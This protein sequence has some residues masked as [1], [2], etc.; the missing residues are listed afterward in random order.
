MTR[1]HPLPALRARAL[2]M[3]LSAGLVGSLA[4]LSLGLSAQPLPSTQAHQGN[5]ASQANQPTPP[6]LLIQ[7]APAR[8]PMS[9]FVVSVPVGEGGKLG[10]LERADRHCQALA[11]SAGAAPGLLWRAYLSTQGR[12]APGASP[13]GVDARDRIGTGPW[14]NAAGTLVATDLGELHRQGAPRL[15][16]RTALDE[17]GQPVPGAVHDILTGSR[18]DGTAASPLDADATCGNWTL[19]EDVDGEGRANGALVGHHDRGSALKGA[20][21]ESWNSAHRTRGCSGPKLAELGSGARFYCFAQPAPKDTA[22]A[23]P[24]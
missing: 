10:G 3:A 12:L 2:D 14:H 17:K 6:T 9:F 5:Q 20:W 21:A 13:M 19:S 1:S 11:S 18:P 22:S 16:R 7:P 8:P 15:D 23:G 24:K 4:G